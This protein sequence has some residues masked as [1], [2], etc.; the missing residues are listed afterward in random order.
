[1]IIW[2]DPAD[3]QPDPGAAV[4][5]SRSAPS[6]A[7]TS[8]TR[9]CCASCTTS[10]ARAGS[11]RPCS[12]STAIPPKSCAPARRRSCSRPSTRS[13]SCSKRPAR[14]TKCLVL[15]FDETRS[16]EPAEDFVSE[17]LAGVLDTRLVVV[18]DDFHF[19]YKRHG[20]VPLL[21][22]MGAELGFE[23]LGL[24]PHRVARIGGRARRRCSLLVHPGARAAR[25]RRR[26]AR[27]RDP[28]PAPRGART[29]RA[30]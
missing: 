18:G 12:P 23:V 21:K 22:R 2:R 14:S 13:S 19:G 20:D 16:K 30:R 25:P 17:V 3:V 28:R 24:R 27:G 11:R 10:P 1:M 7:C 26:R 29:G 6:T 9:R 15:P 8:V 5:R 4:A